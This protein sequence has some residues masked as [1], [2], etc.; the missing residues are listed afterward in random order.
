MFPLNNKLKN[1]LLVR[2]NN[3][4]S[5]IIYLHLRLAHFSS[6]YN[7]CG[8]PEFKIQNLIFQKA[9][10]LCCIRWSMAGFR[11]HPCILCRKSCQ[12]SRLSGACCFPETA[13]QFRLQISNCRRS[14]LKCCKLSSPPHSLYSSRNFPL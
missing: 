10:Q 5:E 3:N 14:A 9:W 7:I 1:N 6:N 2:F 12:G 11:I 8:F 13:L 4:F